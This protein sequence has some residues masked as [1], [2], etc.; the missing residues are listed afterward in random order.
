MMSNEMFDSTPYDDRPRREEMYRLYMAYDDGERC[1][2][3]GRLR[4]VKS[5]RSF[6]FYAPQFW[7]MI[8]RMKLLSDQIDERELSILLRELETVLAA[9]VPGDVVEFG[10][11]V[12]TA[13]VPLAKRLMRTDKTLSVYDSFEGL[14][15]KATQ[16]E[17]PVG[18]QFKK[19]ELFASKKQL[20]KNFK[21]AGVP[22]P[23]IVKGWFSDTT[24]EQ[25]PQR[26]SFAYLDGD[27]YH[28]VLDP[29]KLI[30]PRLV[31]SAV[32]IVDDYA[33]EALPGAAKAV[34]EWL[35]KH[36]AKLQIEHSMA[37]IRT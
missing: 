29:L 14:P 35:K 24:P 15:D 36:P 2:K 27:Y 19:G 10:C 33:N 20:I 21:Q 26:I 6:Y 37:I 8:K 25:V 32:V 18:L 3:L 9:Q 22:L 16:D 23:H 34:N 5:V 7:R 13:S 28:S 17:S 4:E 11:Y 12:G 31:P 1:R 30:W